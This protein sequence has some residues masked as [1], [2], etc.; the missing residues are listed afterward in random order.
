M[1][2]EL[3]GTA[4]VV[5]G[6]AVVSTVGTAF[7]TILNTIENRLKQLEQQGNRTTVLRTTIKEA[8]DLEQ[9]L[10]AVGDKGSDAAADLQIRLDK[11]RKNLRD[12]Q[13]DVSRLTETYES[14]GRVIEGIEQQ[15]KGLQSIAEGKQLLGKSRTVITSMM[16]PVQTA[17]TFDNKVGE[18]VGNAG[19]RGLEERAA[20][21]ALVSGKASEISRDTG[22][23]AAGAVGLIGQLVQQGLKLDKALELAPSV[24]KFSVSQGVDQ[25]EAVQLAVALSKSDVDSGAKME[26]VLGGYAA[27]A[28]AG[29]LRIAEM[30]RSVTKLL[31]EMTA[32]GLKGGYA[33]QQL[34][35][36]TQA[37]AAGGIDAAAGVENIKG[38]LA[39]LKPGTV[40]E[41]ASQFEKAM[42]SEQARKGYATA[43]EASAQGSGALDS[44]M[45]QRRADPGYQLQA[46]SNS[47]EE[48][49]RS[50]G[51]ILLPYVGK[52]AEGFTTVTQAVT[53][54][55]N[56]CQPVVLVLS[57]L[58]AG[59]AAL[60]A[61]A[62]AYRIGKGVLDVGR[63]MYKQSSGSAGGQGRG[64]V[65]ASLT[66][67]ALD[68]L[69]LGGSSNDGPAAA[70]NAGGSLAA[71]SQ[72]VDVRVV[73]M[74]DLRWRPV[75][76]AGDGYGGRKNTTGSGVET[77][78]V[79]PPEK[80]TVSGNQQQGRKEKAKKKKGQQNIFGND[81]HEISVGPRDFAYNSGV[82]GDSPA[83]G[84]AG[85][86]GNKKR[87]Q[88]KVKNRG[89]R[90]GAGDDSENM[91]FSQHDDI[92]GS[93]VLG[94]FLGS[95]FSGGR[96]AVSSPGFGSSLSMGAMKGALKRLPGA[97][98]VDG[99]MM[100]LDVVRNATTPEERAEGLGTA[101]G[102]AGG[103][104]AG[105]AIGA[106]IG[107]V[108]IPIPGVGAAIGGMVGASLGADAGADFGAWLGRLW[109]GSGDKE[110]PS[111][112]PQTQIAATSNS[113]SPV[114]RHVGEVSRSWREGQAADMPGLERVSVV[115]P[116]D[117]VSAG[118]SPPLPGNSSLPTTASGPVQQNI[119]LSPSI[120][121]TV[122]GNIT[123]P[124]DL[125][126]MLA[127]AIQ[128]MFS[129]LAA[130]ANQGSSLWD[131]PATTYIA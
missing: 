71:R 70:S 6:S 31:P 8:T 51:A 39:T 37:Q 90:G 28:A 10:G 30:T 19:V 124:N 81:I 89:R 44:Q 104:M 93:G 120:P 56:K 94:D 121:I 85:S 126:R 59:V 80:A 48:L 52:A 38:A 76:N 16:K 99:A 128:Q 72:P 57:G 74:G 129:D 122:Q 119:V 108:L 41:N 13:V 32:K 82:P 101:A 77:N 106:A 24:A 54:L 3:G 84:F 65:A 1:A 4:T 86:S 15:R 34:G 2:S 118:A 25:K 58:A 95:S 69:G 116:L 21:K 9:Q 113:S 112:S 7:G 50:Y 130:K 79:R 66:R 45:D 115:H 49:K 68:A 117:A 53:D 18:V 96:R 29:E 98:L 43:M 75:G 123:D 109:S 42:G 67:V 20:A 33:A 110:K 11:V 22:M 62:G 105:G 91:R 83:M 27:Q 26:S 127:P 73:N 63:G 88:G 35:A 92:Y 87:A 131:N 114:D 17:A 47:L 125:V 102:T 60:G 14:L 64:S 46:A 40:V 78:A 103:S 97:S 5:V 55:M 36:M 12:Q 107:Q 61:A 23:D 111:T 100:A